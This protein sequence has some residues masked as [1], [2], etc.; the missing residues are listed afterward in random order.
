ML[1]PCLVATGNSKPT[2]LL[3]SLYDSL[4]AGLSWKRALKETLQPVLGSALSSS[5]STSMRVNGSKG[6][7]STH[8][9]PPF[10]PSQRGIENT[11]LSNQLSV[12]SC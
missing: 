1:E 2:L 8:H 11:Y 12:A 10:L 9:S 6:L 5:Q 3:G 7:D 4:L